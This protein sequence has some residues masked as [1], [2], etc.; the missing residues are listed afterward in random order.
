MLEQIWTLQPH[1]LS[2]ASGRESGAWQWQSMATHFHR[3]LVLLEVS[4]KNKPQLPMFP[5]PA[6]CRKNTLACSNPKRVRSR[7]LFLSFAFSIGLCR[8]VR[9][10]FRIRFGR[11]DSADGLMPREKIAEQLISLGCIRC[12][13]IG[14]FADVVF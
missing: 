4:D 14:A 5:D 1:D 11:H 2:E 9:I 13:Q 8:C 6:S 12:G 3:L 7:L 10:V